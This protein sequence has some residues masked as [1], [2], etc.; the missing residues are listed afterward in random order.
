MT[1][2]KKTVSILGGSIGGVI[3][4]GE[5]RKSGVDV[6]IYEKGSEIGGLYK[7]VA[8]PFGEQEFGMHVLYVSPPQLKI[9]NEIFAA[10]EVKIL[11]GIHVDIGAAFAN[12][13]IRL[14]SHY[15]SAIG[16]VRQGEILQQ[17]VSRPAVTKSSSTAEHEILARF[18]TI[19]G[20]EIVLPIIERLWLE[21]ASNLTPESLHCYFDLRRIVACSEGRAAELK[22]RPEVDTVLANP[23]QFKPSGSVFSGRV[24]ICFHPESGLLSKRINDWAEKKKIK[25]KYDADISIKD[26]LL[27]ACGD[28][29]ADNYD[30]GV[31]AMP[32][33]AICDFGGADMDVRQ[34]SIYYLKLDV[35]LARCCPAYYV[36][37]Q[38]NSFRISRLVNYDAYS[39]PVHKSAGSVVA[40]EALHKLG[41]APS[42]ED[43]ESE[44][45]MMFPDFN[46][47]G[48]FE[49]KRKL[50][51]LSPT[52][53]NKC[54]LDRLEKKIKASYAGKPV[55]FTGMRTDA[56]VF[57]SHQTIGAAYQAALDCTE[58]FSRN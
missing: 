10:D 51:I 41:D 21:A 47:E 50:K 52:L 29:L 37:N 1:Q 24:G 46:V 19:A 48:S 55:Y 54:N 20:K 49:V 14:N 33:N 28:S 16:H 27:T 13:R 36:V 18:G 56:G 26:G 8:T 25:I 4:A 39:P 9:I 15:P 11:R 53:K 23:N 12:G 34:L 5:L 44:V 32:L 43:I 35:D 58:R 2:I 7:T 22:N 6:T 31:I 40:A 30:G 3:A 38:D 57:F 17:I 42:L 45:E